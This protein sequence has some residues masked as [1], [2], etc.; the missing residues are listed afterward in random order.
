MAG[1]YFRRSQSASTRCKVTLT[2]FRQFE[3]TGIVLN[4]SQ[5]AR[6]DVVLQIGQVTETVNVDANA[7]L[8]NTVDGETGQVV[9]HKNIV[10]L[11]LKGRQFLELAFLT[12][13]AVNA[14]ERLPG[15]PAGYCAGGQRQPARGQLL[16][17]QRSLERRTV[18]RPV[19]D[20]AVG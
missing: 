20:R 18:R 2:G 15:R 9:N 13:G 12:T 8:V 10:E 19:R 11:P 3:Q 17:A 6:I 7:S 16:H 14:P 5:K 1:T 4:V